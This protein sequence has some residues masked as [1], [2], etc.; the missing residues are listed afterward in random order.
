[1][2]FP[3]TLKK[4]LSFVLVAIALLILLTACTDLEEEPLPQVSSD[5]T[6][7]PDQESWASVI[8]ISQNGRPVAL[9]WASYVASFQKE[10]KTYLKDSVHVD[11]YDREG[12][13]TSVLTAREGVYEEKSRNLTAMGN[14]VVVSDSGMVLETQELKW[15]NDRQ[16]IV[17][18][19][20]VRFV[21]AN[22]TIWGRSFESDPDL[23]N[24]SISGARGRS[25]RNVPL[26]KQNSGGQ[27]P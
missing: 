6:K 21:T 4:L 15:H 12:E 17:S 20:P 11:F 2:R 16:K 27:R 18:R 9:V 23:K 19:V 7:L 3:V 25:S 5:S 24:Y 14:V 1:M 13:H 22:D 10:G 26:E 8:T